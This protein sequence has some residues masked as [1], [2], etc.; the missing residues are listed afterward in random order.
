MSEKVFAEV[1]VDVSNFNVDRPFHYR[2]PDC[3]QSLAELGMRV[4]VPFSGRKVEGYI[5]GF[6]S[7]PEVDEVKDIEDLIDDVPL[8]TPDLVKLAEWISNEYI[9]LK[10]HVLQ[11]M[12]PTGIKVESMKRVKLLGSF[13]AIEES[14][15]SGQGR[16]QRHAVLE[17]LLKHKNGVG[18]DEISS[19]LGILNLS[20]VLKPL[21]NEGLVQVDTLW[22][23][24]VVRPKM[25]KAVYL[26]K[27]TQEIASEIATLETSAPKQAAVL[28]VLL[29]N[30]GKLLN[31]SSVAKMAGTS[32]STI[33]T[34]EAKGYV[35]YREVE[36][37]RDPFSDDVVEQDKAKDLTLE[38]KQVLAEINEAL[39]K[40]TPDVFLLH[41]ITGSGKTEV[42]LQAIDKA[43]SMNKDAILLVPEISLTP[44]MVRT[45]R[46]R[47]GDNVA[48]LHSRLSHGERYDEWRRICRGDVKIAVGARSAI[49]APFK[50]VGLII[51]DEEHETSYKQSM[52]PKYHAREVAIERSKLMNASVVLGSAT[53]SLESYHLAKEG[54]YR[55]SQLPRRIGD[56]PLPLVH[57][58]DMREELKSGNR[59]MFSRL[60]QTKMEET[61]SRGQQIILF[62]NRRGFST[63]VLC[64]ECGHVLTCRECDVSLVYHAD[65]I[66]MMCHY[67]GYSANVPDICPECGSRYI[68]YFGVG[69]QRVQDEV[70]KLFP[71][72]R[73]IRMDADTT[74]R[75]GS[76]ARILKGFE[77]REVDILIGTQMVAK[78]FDF[79]NVTLVGVIS[80]DTA[81]NLPDF[82]SSERTFQLLAQVAGRAG[83]GWTPGEVVVQTYDPEHFSIEAAKTHDYKSFAKQELME[84]K[85]LNFSPFCRL[86]RVV[87]SDKLEEKAFSLAHAF[88]R[89]LEDEK[90]SDW[91]LLGPAS[92]PIP[93]LKGN[94]RVHM[95]LKVFQMEKAREKVRNC[96]RELY[97]DFGTTRVSVDV[98]PLGML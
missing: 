38:Q 95:V 18:Y 82:R 70:I 49:F 42:Y 23:K 92:C 12:L 5:V 85:A 40:G 67:C 56:R 22:S 15:K 86:I 55:Y 88:A 31:A 50:N 63:F 94:S 64:R 6:V 16:T 77:N 83:R 60:L 98:D 36:V 21:E 79:P 52:D 73:V 24:P 58:V 93:R 32:V 35:E 46:R 53:P 71:T 17:Y 66:R 8:L 19:E 14:I 47:F 84:R 65:T 48:V 61:L 74:G 80:A 91:E 3:L 34:L 59:T 90:S 97:D 41:G 29:E 54:E 25:M 78:G 7:S 10:V 62:L 30:P 76:H 37:E 72:T 27:N 89:M 33:R 39:E 51:I 9:C 13:E 28:S 11:S 20:G 2:V 45:F 96:M 69:T 57:V 26:G 87:F 75:K 43:V 68:K 4:K 44:H 1:I 81:L